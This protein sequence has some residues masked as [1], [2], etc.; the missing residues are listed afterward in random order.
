MKKIKLSR[1]NLETL[2]DDEDYD[3]LSNFKWYV[4]T[5]TGKH[6][7]AIADIDK[8]RTS[9]HRYILNAPPHLV[10]DHINHETLDNQRSNLRLLTQT[11]NKQHRRKGRGVVKPVHHKIKGKTYTYWQGV[12]KYYGKTYQTTSCNTEEEASG[13]LKQMIVDKKL[14]IKETT[15]ILLT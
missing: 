6:P 3:N 11:A 2:V 10:V 15:E 13:A 12:I 14:N 4:S 5:Y 8:R 1:S 7:Y 9:M